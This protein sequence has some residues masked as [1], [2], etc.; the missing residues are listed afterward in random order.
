MICRMGH[1]FAPFLLPVACICGILV[2][3]KGA[4]PG[5]SP[6]GAEVRGIFVAH[7]LEL[8]CH[9]QQCPEQGCAVVVQ[10]LHQVGLKDEAAQLDQVAGALAARL[11]PIAGVGQGASG[12]EAITHHYQPPQPCRYRQEVRP[13][14]RRHLPCCPACPCRLAERGPGRVRPTS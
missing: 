10:Q 14:V 4:H 3:F 8:C 1:G 11:G 13:Q 12:V 9:V 5:P 6:A 7:A 2:R